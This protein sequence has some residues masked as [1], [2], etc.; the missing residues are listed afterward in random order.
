MGLTCTVIVGEESVA[1][2]AKLVW[3]ADTVMAAGLMTWLDSV[4]MV[5]SVVMGVTREALELS[6]VP[7]AKEEDT[8]PVTVPRVVTP[9]GIENWK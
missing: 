4:A 2:E 5:P 9:G 1:V 6:A 7:P 3:A 8:V